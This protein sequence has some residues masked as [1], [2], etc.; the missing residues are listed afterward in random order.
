MNTQVEDIRKETEKIL[1]ERSSQSEK[2]EK[3]LKIGLTN[4]D[5]Q[6]LFLQNA[7]QRRWQKR[8]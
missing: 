5:I 6:Q 8:T 4:S 3:L 7:L 2:R 1:K